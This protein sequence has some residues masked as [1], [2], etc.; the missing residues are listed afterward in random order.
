[1]Y[2][3]WRLNNSINQLCAKLNIAYG[4]PYGITSNQHCI[5][6]T[7]TFMQNTIGS[8]STEIMD[9][10][11]VRVVNGNHFRWRREMRNDRGFSHYVLFPNN[12]SRK[13][14]PAHLEG[15]HTNAGFVHGNCYTCKHV[16]TSFLFSYEIALMSTDLYYLVNLV[17]DYKGQPWVN[18]CPALRE[19]AKTQPSWVEQQRRGIDR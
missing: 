2:C 4:K 16:D 8:L 19:L 7:F 12:V 10:N 14:R 11:I 6:V 1:M 5:R 13:C 15:H 17:T 9:H 18:R 3:P